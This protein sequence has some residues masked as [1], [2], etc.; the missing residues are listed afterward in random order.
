MDYPKPGSNIITA[1]DAYKET[2]Y[3]M[4]E[5]GTKHIGSYLEART[6]G[7]YKDIVFFGLQHKLKEYFWGTV[8][9]K[10]KINFADWLCKQTFQQDLFNRAGWEYILDKHQ[11]KLPVKIRAVKE[12]TVVPEDNVLLTI[13]NTDPNCAWLVN[14]LENPIST[15]VVPMHRCYN[16]SCTKVHPKRRT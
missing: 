11:G 16:I 2:H 3:K 8:V 14:H 13:Q 6:D 10:D 15:A 5:D 12:G 1:T 4:Y 9:T 7:E